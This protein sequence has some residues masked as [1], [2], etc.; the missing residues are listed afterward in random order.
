M[1]V[2][3]SCSSS[4]PP[5]PLKWGC[6]SLC[7]HSLHILD[8]SSLLVLIVSLT[9]RSFK[10]LMMLVYVGYFLFCIYSFLHPKNSLLTLYHKDFLPFFF[11]WTLSSLS[12]GSKIDLSL[13]V[14]RD[15][16]APK[17]WDLMADDLR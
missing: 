12:Y 2:D 6:L 10:F 16:G 3:H 4:V 15:P 17:L 13:P 7:R 9:N 8:T 1:L 11:F 14:C 5:T